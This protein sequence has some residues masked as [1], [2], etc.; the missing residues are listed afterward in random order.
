METEKFV[1]RFVLGPMQ[2]NTYLLGEKYVIDPGGWNS[3]LAEALAEAGDNLEAILLTHG[4]YD[5]ICGITKIWKKYPELNLYCHEKEAKL[6]NNAEQNLSSLMEDE[7]TFTPDEIF[8]DVKISLNDT[9]IEVILLPGHTPGGC[10]FY[11]AAEEL[12]F[13]G[14]ILFKGGIGR[15]DFFGGD[16]KTLTSTLE[17]FVEQLPEQ[18]IIYPGHGPET[19]LAREKESNPYL[20]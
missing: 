17:K 10:G 20:Q 2:T 8:P 1:Q 4:H 7:I 14:D 11:L 9:E 3:E 12:I 16:R 15:T 5:H 18:T 13:S 6:L 19:T